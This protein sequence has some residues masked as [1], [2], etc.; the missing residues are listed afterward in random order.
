M[1]RK[2]QKTAGESRI[3]CYPV[4]VESPHSMG[5][6]ERYHGVLCRVFNRASED[7]PDINAELFLAAAIKVIY[8]L[9]RI[10]GLVPTVL[11]F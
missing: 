2:F 10:D 1:S 4:A 5:I 7:H 6:G 8:D 9:A 3:I 11:V